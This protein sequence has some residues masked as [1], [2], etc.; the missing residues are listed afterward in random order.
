MMIVLDFCES[1][2]FDCLV[3]SFDFFGFYDSELFS[4]LFLCETNFIMFDNYSA[5]NGLGAFAFCFYYPLFSFFYFLSY[6]TF[7]FLFVDCFY[8]FYCKCY[9]SFLSVL[10][11]FSAGFELLL[12][13]SFLLFK[14]LLFSSFSFLVTITQVTSSQSLKTLPTLRLD[15]TK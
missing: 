2:G 8:Y 13:F 9:G 4:D 11:L 1:F 7:L 6:S 12:S 3:S 14:W 5:V 15:A 10:F